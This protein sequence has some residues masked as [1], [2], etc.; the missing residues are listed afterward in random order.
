MR[1]LTARAADPYQIHVETPHEVFTDTHDA[2]STTR[3]SNVVFAV[4]LQTVVMSRS[5]TMSSGRGWRRFSGRR[6]RWLDW[7]TSP[8][9]H[10]APAAPPAVRWEQ[11]PDA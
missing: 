10:A 2:M 11:G 8:V 9:S 7:S 4:G 5:A 3:G 6:S 1:E